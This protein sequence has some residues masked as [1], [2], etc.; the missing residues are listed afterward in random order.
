M[1]VKLELHSGEQIAYQDVDR[2][3]DP[4]KYQITI[5]GERG[6]LAIVNK[7]DIKNLLTEEN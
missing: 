3:G 4:D 1:K 5:Y 2:I 7:G 6:I